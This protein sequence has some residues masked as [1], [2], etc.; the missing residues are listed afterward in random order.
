MNIFLLKSNFA[1]LGTLCEALTINEVLD[2]ALINN[3]MEYIQP[4][5]IVA[6]YNKT[7]RVKENERPK[8]PEEVINPFTATR[9]NISMFHAAH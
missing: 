2:E 1:L 4:G 6:S 3:K 9:T 5:Y 7:G 8:P